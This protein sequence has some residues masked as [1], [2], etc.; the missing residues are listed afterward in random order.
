MPHFNAEKILQNFFL[1]PSNSPE[2]MED[3]QLAQTIIEF[4]AAQNGD[5]QAA[6]RLWS[7]YYEKLIPAVRTRLGKKLRGKIETMDIV[8][9]VF[10]EAVRGSEAREFESE[11][12]FRA[13][14]NRLV[15][16]R[17]KKEAR[18]FGRQKRN[19]GKEEPLL[20]V[21]GEE[22]KSAKTIGPRPVS[23]V[24]HF[25]EIERLEEALEKLPSEIREIL[26]MRYFEELTYK[27]IGKLIKKSEE[28][29]RKTVN[30]S[31]QLLAREMD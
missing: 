6:D 23:I 8:Q 20:G 30:R 11:G 17:I 27:E 31:I 18:Y 22:K 10:H 12:H 2:E 9:S 26:I 25:D 4:K 7:R 19:S 29:T 21:K 16:N 28:A 3:K 1:L 24:E 5:R 14:L 15:E 13:W